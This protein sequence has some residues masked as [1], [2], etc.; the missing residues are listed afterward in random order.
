MTDTN[1]VNAR[2]VALAA[3]LGRYDLPAAG[4]LLGEITNLHEARLHVVAA[5]Q[6]ANSVIEQHGGDPADV[7]PAVA[8]ELA[9]NGPEE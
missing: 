8:M 2:V 4:L 6:V 3:A 5:V 1:A 7:F 9:T